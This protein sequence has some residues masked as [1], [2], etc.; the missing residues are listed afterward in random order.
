MTYSGDKGRFVYYEAVEKSEIIGESQ[1]I[2]SGQATKLTFAFE[3]TIFRFFPRRRWSDRTPGTRRG[4]G[5]LEAHLTDVLQY[6]MLLNG[7][8]KNE[9]HKDPPRFRS[10]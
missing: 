4:Q 2:L 5:L 1:R 3:S 10:A 7:V 9:N 8:S 6:L